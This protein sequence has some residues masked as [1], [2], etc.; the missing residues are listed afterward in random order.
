M[1]SKKNMSGMST[2][3]FWKVVQAGYHLQYM[4]NTLQLNNGNGTFSDVGPAS[5]A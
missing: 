5:Q 1:R 3:R 2:D 4:F